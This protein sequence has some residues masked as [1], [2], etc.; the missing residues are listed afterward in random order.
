MKNLYL[1]L[2]VAVSLMYG[3]FSMW[4]FAGSRDND[5]HCQQEWMDDINGCMGDG[6][7]IGPAQERCL[8]AAQRAY[9]ACI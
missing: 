9:E 3:S 1:C 7:E 5:L 8:R 6:G 4:S 2:V